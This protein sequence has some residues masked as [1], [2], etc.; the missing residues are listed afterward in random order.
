MKVNS[1][2]TSVK[3]SNFNNQIICSNFTPHPYQQNMMSNKQFS[4]REDPT[5]VVVDQSRA[6]PL[7]IEQA[8]LVLSQ[9]AAQNLPIE[10]D[11]LSTSTF[12]NIKWRRMGIL[13]SDF[14]N[15]TIKN[16]V[17]S[18][19]YQNV[20]MMSNKDSTQR[21][22]PTIV[23]FDQSR[24]P[25]LPTEQ[26]PVAL[27]QSTTPKLPIEGDT[28]STTTF[29][30]LKWRKTSFI[31]SSF[32]DQIVN[33]NF[34]PH[35]YQNVSMMSSKEFS[36][37][38]DP[39]IAMFDQLGVSP[40]R[41]EQDPLALALSTIPSIPIE[42][43]ASFISTSGN[44]K[45]KETYVIENNLNHQTISNNL[46]THSYQK[47]MSKR[48][49]TLRE[50]P[51]IVAFD[52][53]GAT[54]LQGKAASS[55]PAQ[56]TALDHPI[57]KDALNQLVDAHP[58]YIPS[59]VQVALGLFAASLALMLEM[60]DKGGNTISFN[61]FLVTDMLALVTS[62]A[63][64]M[65]V[66]FEFLGKAAWLMKIITW[67]VA[68]C[69]LLAVVAAMFVLMIPI[70]KW[71]VVSFIVAGA[72]VV[73]LLRYRAFIFPTQY[74]TLLDIQICQQYQGLNAV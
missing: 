71:I 39:T 40:L 27:A 54:P 32:N 2:R 24:E 38:E 34:T 45:W 51:A 33:R 65:I 5:I 74:D 30:N 52:Q 43:N 70:V 15:H 60:F 49:S 29:E 36:M 20:N 73:A 23:L 64:A 35:P 12:Q 16:N 56:S 6:A 4:P 26:A 67:V 8:P 63:L 17:T 3:E 57:K 21:E 66:T 42:E 19:L 69:F 22:H 61:L 1:K 59:V 55:V 37:R 44:V 11:A 62:L 68:A 58:Q 41:V 28:P 72:M 31:E 50:D 9:L 25:S 14:N 18:H 7:P 47:V 13:E 10:E 53:S 48:D 46:T